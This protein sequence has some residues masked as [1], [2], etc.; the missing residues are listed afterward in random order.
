[1]SKLCTEYDKNMGV[2]CQSRGW[3]GCQWPD[4][5]GTMAR[6]NQCKV[7]ERSMLDTAAEKLAALQQLRRY[8]SKKCQKDDWNTRHS[9][10]CPTLAVDLVDSVDLV[11]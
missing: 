1:M 9:A 7:L 2:Q 5:P 11:D 4:D 8:C 6:I 10:E 3:L